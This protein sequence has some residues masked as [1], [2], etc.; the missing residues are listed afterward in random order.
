MIFASCNQNKK[1]ITQRQKDSIHWDSIIKLQKKENTERE[2]EEIKQDSIKMVF[3]KL[4]KDSIDEAEK[5]KQDSIKYDKRYK[6]LEIIIEQKIKYDDNFNP[7][8]ICKAENIFSKTIKAIDLRIDCS[9]KISHSKSILGMRNDCIYSKI[10]HIIIKPDKINTFELYSKDIGNNNT[11]SCFKERC[12]IGVYSVLFD[13]GTKL[14][15]EV[16][17]IKELHRIAGE[18]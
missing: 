9:D 15:K 10:L 12:R 4:H 3:Y 17:V 18:D 7:I 2:Y 8:I 11:S 1:Q 6:N 13:D 14:S 5:Y 16:N